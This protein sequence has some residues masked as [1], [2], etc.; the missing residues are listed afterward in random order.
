MRLTPGD[1]TCTHVVIITMHVKVPLVGGRI[2]DWA[3]KNDVP[4]T[5]EAEFAFGDAW[6]ADHPG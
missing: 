6:L 2:A 4:R 3:G 5:L 1:A